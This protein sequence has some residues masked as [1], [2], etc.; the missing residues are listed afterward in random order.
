MFPPISYDMIDYIG[1]FL[2]IG[3]FMFSSVYGADVV[4]VE[5]RIISI[6]ADV[7]DGLPMFSM[8]GYLASAVKEARQR[9]CIAIHNMGVVFP[10]KRITVNLSPANLRKEGTSF[11]LPIAISLLTAFGYLSQECTKNILLIGE[12]G[13]DG[14]IHAVKGVLAMLM[15]GKKQGFSQ[16]IVPKENVK[17]GA[18]LED[19]DVYGVETL[20]QTMKFLRGEFLLNPVKIENIRHFLE[21]S[22]KDDFS[23]IIGQN[24]AKRAAEIAVSGRHN[25]LMIGPPGSG[26]TMLARRLPTIMPSMSLE[27]CLEITKVYSVCGLL[28]REEGIIT[29]RPYR[30]PHHTITATALTGGGRVPMPGEI[31]LASKGILFLDE[32]PEFS[33]NSLE[34]LRQPLEEN[35]VTISRLGRSYEYPSDCVFVAA[36]NPCRCGN[37]PNRDKCRCTIGEIQKY[38]SKISEPLLDRMDLCVETGIFDFKLYGKGDEKS[39]DI[40]KRVESATAIQRKRYEKEPFSYNSELSERAIKKYCMIGK[41]EQEYLEL[42]FQKGNNSIRKITRILK[43]ARTIADLEESETI[44]EEHLTEAIRFRSVEKNYWGVS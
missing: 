22:Y 42:F 34:V 16:F 39:K 40:R 13:L 6:E 19:I 7:H 32:L 12:L 8:V 38:L 5:A 14:K 1:S 24:T 21:A 9:V 29:K 26:K 4:G 33:R 18:I 37:F 41:K 10:A 3:G 17:E 2:G 31:T 20:D 15:E 30:A 43:V 44:K 25:L 23:D 35:K 11:D 28:K 27:E 36:M